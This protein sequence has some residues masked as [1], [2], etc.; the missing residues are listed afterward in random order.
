MSKTAED[1]ASVRKWL[2]LVVEH[3]DE[4]LVGKVRATDHHY[5]RTEKNEQRPVDRRN[6]D[7]GE[8][9]EEWLVGLGYHDFDSQAA[10]AD[11]DRF[12]EVVEQKLG[13]VDT[14]HLE[15]AGLDPAEVLEGGD[16]E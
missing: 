15:A 8:T 9:Y 4:E 6:L 2:Y 10:Y 14:E 5:A 1:S 16:A 12:V 3:P 11:D 7:T 13:E